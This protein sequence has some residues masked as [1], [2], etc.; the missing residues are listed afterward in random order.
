MID[1]IVH[2]KQLARFT[3]ITAIALYIAG[4]APAQKPAP[5]AQAITPEQGKPLP[6][7]TLDA[8]WQLQD[9]AKVP[10]K[11][12]TVSAP[13][14]I[15]ADWYK[16]TVP[17]TVLTSLVNDGVYPE[18]LYGENDR[19]DKI[20]GSLCRTSYWY[21]T[22][23]P[24]PAEYANKNIWL[25]FHGINYIAEVWING[26]DLGSIKGAFV[27]GIFDIAPYVTPNQTATL[28]V[29]ITPPPHPG[30]PHEHTVEDG[31]GRNGGILSEDGPT[32]LCTLGWD[33]IPAMRDRDM[34]IWQKVTL[35]A[36]GPVVVR[37]PT[38][39]SD[40][41]LPRTDSADLT[42]QTLLQNQSNEPQSGNIHATFGDITFDYPVTLAPNE[43]KPITLTPAEIPGLRINNPQL[44][45]PNG[46]GEPHLYKLHLTFDI[47]GTISDARDLSFGIRKV[48]YDLPGS[49]NLTI[50]VN[51]VPIMCKGGDW[52]ID[53]AMKRIPRKRLEAQI[54][55]HQQANFNMIR[56]WVGQSTSDD[57][58]DLCDQYG[59]MVWDEFFQPNRSD[60]P[61]V[62]KMEM[63]LANV[64]DKI[65][66]YR[67][68]PSIVIWCGRNESD[69]APEV[70]DRRIQQIAA[71]LDPS[72]LYHRNSADGRGVRSGGPYRWREPREF[73]IYT[74]AFKTEIGSVSV[75]TLESIHAMMPEMDWETVNDDWAEHDLDHGAQEG[76]R[77]RAPLY[78]DVIAQRYGSV[79]N[80]PDFV[81]KAQL[82]NYEDFRAMYEARFAKLFKPATGVLTWMSN[83]AQPSFVWQIY[84]YDLEAHAS[85]FGARKACE[86]V[87][88]QMNQ[89]NFHVMVI[90]QT[91]R[92]LDNLVAWVR[93]YNLDGTL[94]S[95]HRHF[96]VANP[97]A[98]TDLGVIDWPADLSPVHFVK[99]QL[100]DQNDQVLSDNFYWNA[101]PNH[102]DD[103]TTLQTLP[104]VTLDTHIVRH[105]EEKRFRL[106]V[107]LS[108][109]SSTVALMAHIQLRKKSTNERI[110]PAYYGD[111]YI[112]LLPGEH[113]SI[114][115]DAARSDL[116]SDEPLIVVDGWNVTTTAQSF[117]EGNGPSNIAPNTEA[118]IDSAPTGKWVVMRPTKPETRPS[119]FTPPPQGIFDDD[120]DVGAVIYPGKDEYNALQK[121]YTVTGNGENMWFAAD[122]FHFVWKKVSSDFALEADVMFPVDGKN[123]HR[124]ACLVVRQSLDANSAYADAALHGVGLTSLQYRDETGVNTHE[125][126][127]AISGPQRLRIE[128]HGDYI[129]MLL[130]N[131]G[132]PFQPSGAA[133]RLKLTAP[134]YVG[135]G[136][137]SHEKLVSETAVFS[138]VHLVTN[139]PTTQPQAVLHSTLETIAV[140]ST[141]RHVTYTAAGHFEAPNW[142]PDAKSLIFNR[143]GH[144]W[145][146]P[147]VGGSPTKIDT[148]FANHCNNDHG[149]S[150][151]GKMIAISDQSQ[152]PHQSIIY[153][154]PIT[155]GTP[156][157]VT[158][159]FPSY[160]HGW[161]PDGN[162]LAFCGQRD[163]KF[164][165]FTIP[166]DGGEETRLTT[167]DGLDDGPDFSPDGKF[168]YFNSDR[169]GTMQ[170]WRMQSDGSDPEQITKDDNNNWFAHP[171][172]NG[173]WLV[174]LTY[175]K[176]VKGHPAN[177][178]VTLQLMS[179]PDRK[180]TVLAKLF[181]GQG[182]INVPSWSP[183]SL[184]LAFVSYQLLP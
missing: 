143:D 44:W 60:G 5:V 140:A 31:T 124:K 132:E 89:D 135:L 129:Y 6:E 16:A 8:N 97:S 4:C 82:A 165:I 173:K 138:N 120:T 90:N 175:D 149:L 2:L 10:E 139:M 69:P 1:K 64:R 55:L 80:L 94:N 66:R 99:L 183:D 174:F 168:I 42:L 153:T 145:T 58:Y 13:S 63:Y 65:L 17:G 61:N 95:E 182:T 128:K 166:S 157:R 127:A 158:Q 36:T 50:S 21:R 151:D 147:I 37:D 34:G 86:L 126:Q 118:Q 169:T 102:P 39:S 59:I 88:I 70:I 100:L 152:A 178:D 108:N 87:H 184:R 91:P 7:I 67:S 26:H 131:K 41:P 116:G 133:V 177:K 101:T 62:L 20:P 144:L 114:S 163:G 125:V 96:V 52:G 148:G 160:W 85:L 78:P 136:V 48:T 49:K 181:G 142:T 109:P 72:R 71:E 176:E 107:N 137:C 106:D 93:I 167:T 154:V 29:E 164:G 156:H 51:G 47:D 172:P 57:F 98:A 18:P 84:S 111:N 12:E 162:T 92:S 3:F 24:I 53:E 74:E 134:F 14:Y 38:V 30:I 76:N 15:P 22:Q 117:T 112:S 113:R 28:A 25:N 119:F 45:W 110:L 75:P 130:A 9:I 104:T 54:R 79:A 32:F 40:L 122:A 56:N 43:S 33:W 23:F 155:G 161:S 83:P 27:R 68:H 121:T 19:P 103:F 46:Y 141:D 81:R 171:S 150:P 180:I 77:G 11:G 105:D 179:L 146:I 73:Y 170:I 35:S 123:P 159:K 115:V